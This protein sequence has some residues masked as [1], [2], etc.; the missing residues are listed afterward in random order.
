MELTEMQIALIRE[1]KQ[2]GADKGTVNS[3][4]AKMQTEKQQQV[5]MD[6]MVSIRDKTVN[7]NEVILKALEIK[8][9]Y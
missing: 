5:M 1:L 2:Q 8:E 3:V 9:N 4:L 6:Y 7:K